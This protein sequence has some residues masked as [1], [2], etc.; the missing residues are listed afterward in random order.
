[1]SYTEIEVTEEKTINISVSSKTPFLP[2][3]L[4]EDFAR[5]TSAKIT[6]EFVTQLDIIN[7]SISNQQSRNNRMFIE[8]R[9]GEVKKN[10]A[11]SEDSLMSFQEKHGIVAL[12]VQVIATIEIASIFESELGIAEIKYNV[13]KTTVGK[14]NPEV[15]RMKLEIEQLKLKIS[16]IYSNP[17]NSEIS[18]TSDNK[19]FPFFSEIPELGKYYIRAERD[20]SV[21][22]LIFKFMTQELEKAKIE[23]ARDTPTVHCILD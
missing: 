6:N 5:K 1:M 9:Y 11:A 20:M 4:E 14:N 3:S 23:E 21:Q 12:S 15:R 7:R 13:M 8:Q 22:N 10:L 17:S 16:S 19:F 18:S 2:D